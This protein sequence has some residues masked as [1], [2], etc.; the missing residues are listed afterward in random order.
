MRNICNIRIGL[1]FWFF[2]FFFCYGCFLRVFKCLCCCEF[3][4]Y[5]YLDLEDERISIKFSNEEF[6]NENVKV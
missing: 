4:L 2:Y 5:N 6:Y 1:V 3:F